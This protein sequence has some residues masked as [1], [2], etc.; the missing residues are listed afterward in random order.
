[1]GGGN[2]ISHLMKGEFLILKRVVVGNGTVGVESVSYMAAE[3]AGHT[4]T[5]HITRP[6]QF[7]VPG[8]NSC[9]RTHFLLI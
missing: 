7:E 6:M 2:L 4:K 5:T 1:M 9:R 3:K 8:S